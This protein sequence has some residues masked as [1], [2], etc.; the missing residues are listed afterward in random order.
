VR[1]PNKNATETGQFDREVAEAKRGGVAPSRHLFK[2]SA[3]CAPSLCL[4]AALGHSQTSSALNSRWD[5]AGG[6]VGRG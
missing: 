5:V 4:C 3:S 6:W 1:M 2:D